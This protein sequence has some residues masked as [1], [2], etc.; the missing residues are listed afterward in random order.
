MKNR[1]FCSLWERARAIEVSTATLWL[2]ILCAG[3]L[4]LPAGAFA[5]DAP[6]WMHALA[7]APVPPHDD[8]T[9]AVE[10]YSERIV[11]VQSADKIKTLVRKAYKVIR[12]GG[13]DLGTVVIPFDAATRI[14]SLH[15]W[16]IPA[17]GKDYE[18]KEKD[19][20]EVAMPAIQGSELITDVR[21][22]V[23]HIP[24][25]DP[26]N[27][28][29]YEYEQEDHP[30]VLQDIWY[31]QGAY[32]ARESRY[33]VQLPAGWEYKAY[34]LNHSEVAPKQ[35]GNNQWQ[36]EVS[37]VQG[38]KEEADM[39]P[40]RGIAGQMI[41]SFVPA[42]GAPGKTFVSWRD[43]GLWY[44]ELARGRRDSSPEMKQ[45]VAALTASANTPV[46]KMRALARF[47][48]RDIRYVAIELGI[49]GYQPHPAVDV[50]THRYGDCKDKA[51]LMAAMLK[52][53]GIESYY[54]VIN[55]ERGAVTQEMPAHMGGFD[56]AILAIQLP[57][58]TDDASLVAV[59]QHA[60]L[61]RLLFFDPTSELTAFGELSGP[62]QANYGLL[63]TPEGGELVELPQL[64]TSLNST[65]RT[66]KLALA[67]NGTLSGEIKEVR[68]GDRAS[69]QRY[70]LKSVTKETDKIKPIETLL[71]H[72]L[73]SYRLT[74]L[75]FSNLEQTELPFVF[76]YSVVADHYA[77]SAGNLLLVRPRVV[78]VKTSDLLETKEPRQYP[79]VFDGPSRD[80]DVFEIS[81]PAGYEVDDLPQPV[82]ADFGFASYHSK[83]EVSG[84]VL[85]YARTFEVK[86][87]SVPLAKMEDL[88]KLYRIIANDERNTA[89]LKP[90]VPASA[91]N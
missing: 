1:S 14:S 21:A 85:R 63:V 57:A 77:K 67:P 20:A 12:P 46:E 81:M 24:A 52:E 3:A 50:F 74:K 22:K 13:R 18:V 82:S 88:K 29:G 4:A 16:C 49:G 80:M 69:A 60:K 70:A 55:S 78:G 2:A 40:H 8:K 35:S 68:V 7:S 89:V 41:M 87:P 62:L 19:G 83:A 34:W 72:S 66:A 91:K 37:G 11:T 31:F 6:A 75:S 28:I 79:V 42:G 73:S 48:Q 76:D 45:K 27:L 51:T 30:F 43:M 54:V 9:D 64:A 47:V 53:I 26:G 86:E 84:N 25:A 15:A 58:G 65:V 39:P 71:A 5:G 10:M 33:T 44:T 90:T 32:P 61:G 59:M 38:I 36:W 17:Q 56:H 23:V